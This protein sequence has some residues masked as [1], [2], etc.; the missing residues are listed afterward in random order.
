VPKQF[1]NL[2]DDVFKEVKIN[3]PMKLVDVK[4]IFAKTNMSINVYGLNK[5]KDLIPLRVTK[6]M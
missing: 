4:K 1:G 6:K 3:F 5:N 2:F